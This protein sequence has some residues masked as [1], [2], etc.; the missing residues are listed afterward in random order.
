M[1]SSRNPRKLRL[2]G[3]VVACLLCLGRVVDVAAASPAPGPP[4][5]GDGGGW[6]AW[7]WIDAGEGEHRAALV[8]L[9]GEG[10]ALLS[11]A[12]GLLSSSERG[13][14][15]QAVEAARQG[16]AECL[17]LRQGTSPRRAVLTVETLAASPARHDPAPAVDE[18]VAPPGG[19]EA[20]REWA[21]H[22]E[23]AAGSLPRAIGS[24]ELAFNVNAIRQAFPAEFDG[25]GDARGSAL[26][27]AVGLSN[28]RIVGMHGRVIAP[29]TV[30]SR[31]P[32]L[33]RISGGAPV[34]TYAGPALVTLVASWTARSEPPGRVRLLPLTTA[35]WPA[36]QLGAPPMDAAFVLAARVQWRGVAP[37]L[38]AACSSMLTSEPRADFLSGWSAW[39]RERGASADRLAGSLEPW[40]VGWAVRSG[41]R[42]AGPPAALSWAVAFKP[43][44]GA[45]AAAQALLGAVGSGSGLIEGDPRAVG[46][47]KARFGQSWDWVSTWFRFHDQPGPSDEKP[48]GPARV[49]G[50]LGWSADH[51]P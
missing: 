24:F 30:V 47:A 38:A 48:R 51:A 17:V 31:D 21:A 15:V 6:L 12:S 8:D 50:R 13:A 41:G 4:D 39:Q 7:V 1:T 14:V 49:E 10:L 18:S 33:P 3:G 40:A 9:L 35:Y 45:E 32:T 42:S 22:R 27:R 5:P 11:D 2:C 43:G 28:A 37:F 34:P 29:D 16:K 26:L 23:A 36:Q 44:V 19:P 46:G 20:L 25:G